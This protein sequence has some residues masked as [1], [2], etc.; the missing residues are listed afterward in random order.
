MFL[1]KETD[2]YSK[3]QKSELD[4]N[5]EHY[6]KNLDGI[7]KKK[8]YLYQQLGKKIHRF[9]KMLKEEEEIHSKVRS[10]FYY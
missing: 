5:I 1:S 7:I 9:K 3:A 2:I 6:I 4:D 8:V 10:T